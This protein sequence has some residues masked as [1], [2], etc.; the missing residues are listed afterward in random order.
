M[1]S[2]E[3]SQIPIE[4]KLKR[5]VNVNSRE[6]PDLSRNAKSSSSE[7]SKKLDLFKQ[8]NTIPVNERNGSLLNLELFKNKQLYTFL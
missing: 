8:M 1:W 7:N 2:L 6:K 3:Y 5:I 4:R